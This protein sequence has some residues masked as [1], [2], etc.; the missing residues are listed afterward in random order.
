MF[1]A[2][3]PY[4]RLP[5]FGASDESA[6][7]MIN[8]RWKVHQVY[9][10]AG[11]GTSVFCG[12]VTSAASERSGKVESSGNSPVAV[13]ATAASKPSTE[14]REVTVKI[15]WQ[16]ES[17]SYQAEGPGEASTMGFKMDALGHHPDPLFACDVPECS[18]WFIRKKLGLERAEDRRPSRFLRLAVFLRPRCITTLVGAAFMKAWLDCVRSRYALWE[19]G[20]E[21]VKPRLSILMAGEGDRGFLIDWE[22]ATM[23]G[24]SSHDEASHLET[25][26]FMALDLLDE[27]YWAGK[28]KRQYHHGLEGFL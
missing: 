21:D 27:E 4:T 14:L 15:Y 17:R 3:T 25:V 26:P 11:R 16:E 5:A 7:I 2:A 1:I 23:F 10:L 19:L 13:G 24:Q 6:R 18:T 8:I 28:I 22:L 9:G 20:I 12:T